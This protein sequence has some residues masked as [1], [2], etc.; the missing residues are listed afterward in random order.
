MSAVLLIS[1]GKGSFTYKSNFE[2]TSFQKRFFWL[3]MQMVI[4]F[5]ILYGVA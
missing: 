3:E 4:K 5:G 2:V 1:T